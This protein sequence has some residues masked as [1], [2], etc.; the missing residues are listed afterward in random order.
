L[1]EKKGFRYLIEAA[2]RLDGVHIAIVG[3]GDLRE[4]LEEAAL[5]SGASIGFTGNL[6][7]STVSEVVAAADVVAVPSVIDA[8]GNVDG[9]PTTLL[10]ALATGRAVVASAIAGI[11]EVV[12]DQQNG[13]LVPEKDVD[14]LA[15]ALAE[16]R[17]HPQLRE[18]LGQEARRRALIELGWDATV[19][20]FE[21]AYGAART[22]QAT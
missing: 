11:P 14:G 7:R 3:E 16:L 6:E 17:D 8:T 12:S 2:A 20:A 19:A 21:Q 10:E 22:R 18:R 9:L 1:V 4:E 13:L 15:R 5:S